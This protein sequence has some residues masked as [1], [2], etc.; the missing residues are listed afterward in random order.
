MEPGDV[1]PDPLD[2]AVALEQVEAVT[3][4][5]LRSSWAGLRSF[6]ADRAPVVGAWPQHPGFHFF[7]GQGGCGIESA[8]ALA[9]LTTAKS[10]STGS[11]VLHW[12]SRHVVSPFG[13]ETLQGCGDP[14]DRLL[15]DIST[16]G[17]V[18]GHDSLP[19]GSGTMR[20]AVP[21]PLQRRTS[22]VRSR[23]STGAACS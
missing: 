1:R 14:A 3:G 20:P 2:V 6:V 4:L 10:P 19:M 12:G 9:A 5:G 13:L 21:T 22:A 17:E 18:A 11:G 7:A 8:P 23:G 15:V 16:R